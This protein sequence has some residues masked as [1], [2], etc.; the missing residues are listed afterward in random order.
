VTTE[1]R[2]V[3]L[4]EANVA[5]SA[6]HRLMVVLAAPGC[7]WTRK[8][9]GCTNCAFPGGL[10]VGHA[11][12]TA[13]LVAQTEAALGRLPDRAGGQAHLDLYVSGSFFNPE[14]IPEE[15]QRQ[16]LSTAA[17]CGRL[18]RVTV[19]SR[20]EY[21]TGER[22][23]A[24]RAALGQ[25]S[26]EVAI[27]LESADEQIRLRRI[28]KGFSW[29]QFVAAAQ[30]IAVAGAELAV[31]VLL[32]PI[33]TGE[34]EAIDDAVTTIE[35]VSAL[36]DSL[37]LRVR[38]ALEPCFVAPATPLAERH[39]AGDY[40]PPWLWSVVEVLRRAAHLRPVHVGLSDEQLEPGAV[41][42]NCA[43]CDPQIRAALARFN[44]DGRLA[45][46]LQ[47]DCT[48]RAAWKRAVTAPAARAGAGPHH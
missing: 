3:E 21:V 17:A 5:G 48:C 4:G 34:R 11:V 23:D 10:G 8:T 29:D 31:Y 16:I 22:L 24:A 39:A 40:R 19:E 38:I 44:R 25:L 41:A 30:R 45:E 15:A 12:S 33:D 9:G 6:G 47:L 27:G 1:P 20:P 28:R 14:E 42:H 36:G 32:K 26:L 37:D 2:L 7:A 43:Q 18:A 13:E 46:L 35:R